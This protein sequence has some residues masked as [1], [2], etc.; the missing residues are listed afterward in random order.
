MQHKGMV[1]LTLLLLSVHTI[2]AA[3]IVAPSLPEIAKVFSTTSNADLLSKLILSLPAIL[4]AVSAP[5]AGRYIDRNGRIKLLYVGLIL[6]AMAGSSAY[7]L[8]NLYYILVGRI[9]LGVSIGIIMTITVTLIGDYFEGE[10][11]K[12]F[13]GFQTAFIGFAGVAFLGVGGLLADINWRMPFLIYVLALLIIPLVYKFLSE[14]E[15][16][17]KTAAAKSVR[18]NNLIGIIFV[19]AIAFMILFY[20]IPTQLPFFLKEI[21]IES[22]SLSGAVLSL[23]ALG[24]VISSL[25]YSHIRGIVHY[26]YIFAIAFFLMA[27]GFTVTA[28]GSSLLVVSFAML[29][30]GLGFGLII[31]NTNLWMIELTPAAYRGRNLGV[32]NSFMFFGQFLSPIV[33]EPIVRSFN[34]SMVFLLAA[35]LLLFISL[36]FAVMGRSLMRMDRV[37]SKMLRRS[38]RNDL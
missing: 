12:Q 20:I 29:V 31:P 25:M 16:V 28:A 34:L 22:N 8:N 37:Y 19:T 32:L 36:S 11:R 23:N 1:K 4:I 38:I 6:Y 35:V 5:L 9:F 18:L 7:L 21:G 14:P 15:V 17:V 30:A 2:M 27:I 33:V 24:L 3:A 10:D 13:L 26:T